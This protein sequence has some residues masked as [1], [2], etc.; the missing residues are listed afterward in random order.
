MLN[1]VEKFQKIIVDWSSPHENSLKDSS[2]EIGEFIN[3]LEQSPFRYTLPFNKDLFTWIEKMIQDAVDSNSPIYISS[4]IINYDEIVQ[5]LVKAAKS[6]KGKIFVLTSFKVTEI[7]QMTRSIEEENAHYT[8]IATLISNGVRMRE[9]PDNHWKFILTNSHGII[10]SANLT[11]N[12]LQLGPEIGIVLTQ[13]QISKIYCIFTDTWKFHTTNEI[14]TKSYGLKPHN[15]EHECKIN[16]FGVKARFLF[17]LNLEKHKTEILKWIEMAQDTIDITTFSLTDHEII[18]ALN[19]SQARVRIIL[20]GAMLRSQK[21]LK[22]IRKL[23][24]SIEY[25]ICMENHSKII[26]IDNRKFILSTGNLDQYLAEP[27]YDVS[28]FSKNSNYAGELTRYFEYLWRI[29][30]FSD[31]SLETQD[32]MWDE[33]CEFTILVDTPLNVNPDFN[34]SVDKLIENINNAEMIK[35]YR[36]DEITYLYF[37]I[38]SQESLVKLHQTPT[39]YF[40]QRISKLDW[41]RIK[42]DAKVYCY[43]RIIFSLV[44]QRFS[45]EAILAD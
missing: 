33:I 38:Q 32:T 19:A 6:L 8:A 44:W 20:P 36:F 23:N 28:I 24:S 35:I 34:F 4:F 41:D 17:N 40:T 16:E 21:K 37:T 9:N 25:K 13:E 3:G 43:D 18:E 45:R 2:A 12:S 42:S 30:N 22:E 26:I 31:N 29:A 5:L 27:N 39:H 10:M 1:D 15:I 14:S 7:R 11:F